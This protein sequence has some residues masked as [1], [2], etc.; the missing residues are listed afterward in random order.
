M[1]WPTAACLC[2]AGLLAS[3]PAL[4]DLSGCDP[5]EIPAAA[6]KGLRK[7]AKHE[8][9]EALDLKTLFYCTNR[10]SGLATVDTVAEPNPDGTESLGTLNCSGAKGSQRGWFCR[11]NRYQAIRL[12]A[13]PAQPEVR[14]E[15][16]EG[17]SLESTREYARRAFALLN[18][19][20]RVE[21]CPGPTASSQTTES[22]RAILARRYGPYRL[23]ISREGFALM[24]VDIQVRYRSG[25]AFNPRARFQ[26]WE[27]QAVE[28]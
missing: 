7:A 8:F 1:M 5:A 22:L 20:G 12:S 11:V 4:A 21:A 9:V 13:G 2:V 27:E 26:C 23:V 10:E 18:E 14:V 19:P 6:L 17:V 25:D 28:E 15:V 16:G 3:G 24:R